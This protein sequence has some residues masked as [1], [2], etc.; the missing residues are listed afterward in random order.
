MWDLR[1]Q[2]DDERGQQLNDWINQHAPALRPDSDHLSADDRA[3]ALR[4]IDARMQVL[5]ALHESGA[6]ILMGTDAPQ[7]FSVPGFSLHR[8]L[9]R[10]VDAGMS[11]YAILESGSKNVG[12][13]FANEDEFGT[14][15]VGQ[16]AAVLLAD[17]DH[18]TGI[19][20]V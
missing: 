14:I 20:A 8:E 4:V 7:V 9:E 6:R 17:A 1:G 15:A 5:S 2:L 13:Y 18:R 19:G 10:M 3:A 11:P 12:E 16:R